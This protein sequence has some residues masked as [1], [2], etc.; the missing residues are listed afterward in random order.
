MPAPAFDIPVATENPA[1]RSTFEDGSV[2]TRPKFTRQ[3]RTWSLNLPALSKT[4]REILNAFYIT[5]KGGSQSF[6][7]TDTESEANVTVRFIS[8]SETQKTTGLW[9]VS[10]QI[11]EV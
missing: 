10:V 1:L 9:A 7:W 2:Q 8:F 5:T 11:E 3:R 6:T 4:K